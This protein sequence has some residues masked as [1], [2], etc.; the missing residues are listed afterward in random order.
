MAYEKILRTSWLKDLTATPVTTVDAGFVG[1]YAKNG[2]IYK[3]IG[4][5]EH[6][7]E[8]P[9]TALGEL[10]VHNGTTIVKF[11]KG[12]NTQRLAVVD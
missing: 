5:V 4:T 9:M 1:F 6:P 2:K 10:A 11:P 8:M 7:I 12:S 3:K